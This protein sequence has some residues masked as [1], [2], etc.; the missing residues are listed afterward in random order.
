MSERVTHHAKVYA[1]GSGATLDP[2]SDLDPAEEE[3][4]GGVD[5]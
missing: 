3:E 4:E 2:P 1:K 5:R